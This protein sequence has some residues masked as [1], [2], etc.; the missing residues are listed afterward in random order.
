M[1]T[2]DYSI[3]QELLAKFAKAHGHPARISICNILW[4]QQPISFGDIHSALPMAKATVSQHLTALKDAGL[5]TCEAE[6]TKVRY[7]IN[8]ENWKMAFEFFVEFLA[9]SRCMDERVEGKSL[10]DTGFPIDL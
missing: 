7:S 5:I 1:A 3:K 9:Q 6:G 10:Q 4:K 2:K 8:E